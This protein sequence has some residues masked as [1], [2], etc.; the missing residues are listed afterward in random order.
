MIGRTHH[1]N[2]ESHP[3]SRGDAI[4]IAFSLTLA[5]ALTG[6]LA[7]SLLFGC[8][9]DP[10]DG[11]AFKSAHDEG[12]RTVAVPIFENT[13][14]SSGAETQITE[15]IIKEIQ[16]STR[17][18]VVNSSTSDATLKGTLTS[19]QLRRLASAPFTGLT[20]EYGVE[21]KVDFE[22]RDNRS[23]KPLVVRRNFSALE[24]FAPSSRVGERIEVGQAGTADA[25]ARDIVAELR[26]A[27]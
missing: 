11:Y 15:A 20:Q 21:Y 19:S 7:A 16:R 8:A 5:C 24:T 13:T 2:A 3:A 9:S 12:I 17:W 18:T 25:L 22:F 10:K 26:S 27:W 14:F 1:A 23:G 6:A 4:G